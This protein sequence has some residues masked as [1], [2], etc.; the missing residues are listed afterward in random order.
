MFRF[1]QDLLAWKVSKVIL[2]SKALVVHLDQVVNKALPVPK[3]ALA[4]KAQRVPRAE[5]ENKAYVGRQA[6]LAL[7][8]T[9]D[10][11]LHL[12][13]EDLLGLLEMKENVEKP[14]RKETKAP[15]V[16][17][18]FVAQ[19]DLLDSLV[20]MALM[21]KVVKWVGKGPLVLEVQTVLLAN[22]GNL[23]CLEKLDS[24]VQPAIKV[25]Q[26]QQDLPEL[27]GSKGPRGRSDLQDQKA[28]RDRQVQVV[29][30]EWKET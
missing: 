26:D 15:K 11:M 2:V 27:L 19:L 28:D 13:Q 4:T 30:Q 6:D 9:P 7:M 22:Q 17:R 29:T 21:E 8:V 12:G 5:R 18:D 10:R 3:V 23:V 16:Q 14:E 1:C 25:Q 24:L 20:L